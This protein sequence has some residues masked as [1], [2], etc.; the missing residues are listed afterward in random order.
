ML[1]VLK[2]K[3]ARPLDHGSTT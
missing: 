3:P 1:N 2:T